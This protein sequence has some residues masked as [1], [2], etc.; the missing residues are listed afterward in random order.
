MRNGRLKKLS[1]PLR[2]SSKK[3]SVNSS[4]LS[5]IGNQASGCNIRMRKVI[6]NTLVIKR[7][8]KENLLNNCFRS[9]F[10]PIRS[11]KETF[12]QNEDDEVRKL[13]KFLQK[14]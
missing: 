9:E 1:T 3:L 10:S 6:S 4:I 2:L 7:K 13:V 5:K 8:T 12:M 14:V 11:K